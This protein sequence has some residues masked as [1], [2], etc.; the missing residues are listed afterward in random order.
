MIRACFKLL[1]HCFGCRTDRLAQGLCFATRFKFQKL[2]DSNDALDMA[3]DR[4]LL[5]LATCGTID[6]AYTVAVTEQIQSP[7]ALAREATD[8]SGYGHSRR[9]VIHVALNTPVFHKGEVGRFPWYQG[10]CEVETP[11]INILRRQVV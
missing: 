5:R 2:V 7:D 10:P 11:H 1:F 3:E 8:E 9:C 4:M 6:Y